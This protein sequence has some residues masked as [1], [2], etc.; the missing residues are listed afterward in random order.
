VP[1]AKR[2]KELVDSVLTRRQTTGVPAPAGGDGADAVL[3]PELTARLADLLREDVARL[4][5]HMPP[6]FDGW[7][8]A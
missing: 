1:Q 5:R 4:R 6:S 8:L 7:G 3:P 2:A